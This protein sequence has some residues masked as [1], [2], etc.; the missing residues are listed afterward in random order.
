MMS[1]TL[2]SLEQSVTNAGNSLNNLS[3]KLENVEKNLLPLPPANAEAM[4]LGIAPQE[5]VPQEIPVLELLESVSDVTTEY[6]HLRR[7][8]KE[9]HQ[10]NKEMTSNLKYQIR[11]MN[12]TFS[13]LKKR[14]EAKNLQPHIQAE[15]AHGQRLLQR[16]RSALSLPLPNS[17]TSLFHNQHK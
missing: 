8:L 16:Q 4:A 15:F 17:T 2:Y 5:S 7:D 1:E 3:S 11:I 9:M 13:L 10:L 6:E 14:I 12:E